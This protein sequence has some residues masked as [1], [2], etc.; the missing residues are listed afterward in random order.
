MLP[1]FNERFNMKKIYT[2]ITVLML[3]MLTSCGEST[4]ISETI[5][6]TENSQTEDTTESNTET[7]TIPEQSEKATAPV[8]EVGYEGMTAVYAD[9]LKDG[10]YN[11]T[12]DS[13]SSMFKITECSLKVENGEMTAKMTMSGTGYAYLYMGTGDEASVASESD[14]I[15]YENNGGVHSFTVPVEALDKE[16]DCAA[17]S[18]KK[19]E[20]YDRKLVFRADS[21]P[22]SA[23]ADGSINTA[24]SLG[25]ADGEYTIDVTLEGGSGKSTIQSPTK[26]TVTSGEA[27]A[28]LIWSSNNYD[29]MII[30]GEKYLPV[31]MEENSVFEIPVT[32]FDHK[33]T[34]SADTTAMSQPHEI[35]YTLYFDSD[36]L[37][38]Q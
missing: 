25:L 30:D 15:N 13:S 9:S 5:V 32:V 37:S 16:I 7:E 17:F 8:E 34:V 33:I 29:Y 26:L 23:F 4:E 24:E 27:F 12:V 38:E 20:W 6:T 2:I 31:S 11:I 19:E 28:E 18:K 14:Y 22:I 36:S 10:E 1:D 35:E 3:A 21:I